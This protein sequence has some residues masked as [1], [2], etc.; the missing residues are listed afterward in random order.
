MMAP[1][2]CWVSH[3]C[4]GKCSPRQESCNS[5]MQLKQEKR[6]LASAMAAALAVLSRQT[7][8]V[9]AAFIA[10]VCSHHTAAFISGVCCLH[11]WGVLPSCCKQP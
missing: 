2:M 3:L 1:Q 5:G 4:H 10:W 9:W 7:N 6:W 11:F 8:V